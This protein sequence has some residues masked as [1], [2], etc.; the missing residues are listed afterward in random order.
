M[1]NASSIF[2]FVMLTGKSNPYFFNS[3]IIVSLGSA[4]QLN[5]LKRIKPP[6]KLYFN[7]LYQKSKKNTK[8]K[9]KTKQ[10][11]NINNIKKRYIYI[12]IYNYFFL[13]LIAFL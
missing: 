10:Y 3:K 5:R 8:I 2:L 6:V 4:K 7:L 13:E 11:I 9:S 12:Y 1:R